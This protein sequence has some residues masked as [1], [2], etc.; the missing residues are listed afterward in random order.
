MSLRGNRTPVAPPPDCLKTGQMAP[1]GMVAPGNARVLD[2]AALRRGRQELA[3]PHHAVS[4]ML[5]RHEPE[6]VY[7]VCASAVLSVMATVYR[8]GCAD[9][10]CSNAAP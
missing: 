3:R 6:W 8:S 4:W 5:M 1:D 7:G 10:V 2:C 9:T